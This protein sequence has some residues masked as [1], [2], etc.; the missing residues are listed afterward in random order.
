MAEDPILAWKTL[1]VAAAF[2]VLFAAERIVPSAPRPEPA[3]GRVARNG[4]LWLLNVLLSL[5]FVVPL[6]AWAAG[7]A[8]VWR[9]AWWSGGPGFALDVLL[10]DFLIYWWHRANHEVPFLWRFHA[11]HHLDRFLDTTSAVRF[12]LG[13]VALSA[14]ARAGVIL[15]I[16]F[17]LRSVLA[18]EAILLAATLFHH[19]NARLPAAFENALARVVI[20]PSRHWVHHHRRRAD[21]DSTY[22]TLFSFWDPLFGTTTPTRRT[23][24]MPIGVEGAEERDLVGL[25]VAPF[26]PREGP[27]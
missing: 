3:W 1:A 10:L 4:A 5:G 20:T 13:E 9:P 25:L 15:L 12:H 7:H 21:T 19:S 11:V 14:L 2:L 27:R 17:P 24:T 18:F 23:L 6:T 8:L 26:A 16:G 22:G